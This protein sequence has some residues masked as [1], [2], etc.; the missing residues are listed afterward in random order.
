MNEVQKRYIEFV[1]LMKDRWVPHQGQVELGK[2]LFNQGMDVFGQCGRNFGKSDFVC[3]ALWRWAFLNPGSENYY[4]SP[5]M[6]QSDE[7]L[8]E[9]NRIQRFGHPSW[10]ADLNNSDLRIKLTNGSFIKLD[11]SDNVDSYRGVKPRGLS[12]F[13][14]FKDFRPEFYEAYDPNR[15][16]HNSPLVIIGTPP[17]REGQFLQVAKEYKSDPDKHYYH[18]PTHVNPHI[19]KEWLDKKKAEYERKEELDVWQREYMAIYT[20]GGVSKIFPMLDRS[21][22]KPYKQMMF[23]LRKD[24]RKLEWYCLADPAAATTFAV[25][26]VALNPYDK[27]LYILDEIYEQR[28]SEMTV[29]RIGNRIYE[30]LNQI[31]P[32]AEWWK[33]YDEAETWFANE[34]VSRF[35]DGWMP[36]RKSMRKKEEHISLIKDILLNKRVTVSDRCVKLFWEMDNY[37]K[38]KNDRIPKKD[39]HLLDC[40]RYVLDAANYGIVKENEYIEEKDENFRG[41][42]ISHDYPDLDD[43]GTPVDPWASL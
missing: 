42:R 43:F 11:G 22:V 32:R 10:I 9:S 29:E 27:H 21:V 6:K 26:F 30:T 4:F 7:I 3:Y 37:Y 15:A 33:G 41:A 12:V 40:F 1:Q 17:D 28:Q 20:P 39:D 38:D 31:A 13:D 5:Y 2:P 19:S 23:N 35:D 18:G 24:M 14:E 34:M 16:A 36:T 8:W 25:L